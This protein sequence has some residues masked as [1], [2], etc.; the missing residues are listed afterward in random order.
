MITVILVIF[1]IDLNAILRKI[2]FD[3]TSN[4]FEK[5]Y[6]SIML[7]LTSYIMVNFTLTSVLKS[8]NNKSVYKYI[9]IAFI[10][11]FIFYSEFAILVI[12]WMNH[13]DA[14]KTI[15]ESQI[16]TIIIMILI[17]MS[18]H[19]MFWYMFSKLFGVDISVIVEEKSNPSKH[20]KS[21][22]KNDITLLIV[23][24]SVER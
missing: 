14:N 24:E 18:I 21:T 12:H 10:L 15:N 8:I 22:S 7:L 1:A 17:L 9:A 3:A 4:V 5:V 11:T 23:E 2:C 6:I 13:Y 16:S 20:H 19:C